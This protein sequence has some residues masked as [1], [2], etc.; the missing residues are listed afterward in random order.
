MEL[1]T[2]NDYV[3]TLEAVALEFDFSKNMVGDNS[4][5]MEHSHSQYMHL[6][7]TPKISFEVEQKDKPNDLSSSHKLVRFTAH[8]GFISSSLKMQSKLKGPIKHAPLTKSLQT[9]KK[10][11]NPTAS[12]DP[13]NILMSKKY[14]NYLKYFENKND[15]PDIDQIILKLQK[16]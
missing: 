14:L 11:L 13:N 7:I 8:K 6:D 16:L 15:S 12:K 9:K 10:S 5:N 2:V 4:A 3:E 1:D